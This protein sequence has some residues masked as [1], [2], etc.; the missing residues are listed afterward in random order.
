[1]PLTL[2]RSYLRSEPSSSATAAPSCWARATAGPT[3]S[4]GPA[5][6][7][8]ERG[9]QGV[10]S[11]KSHSGHDML[12]THIYFVKNRRHRRKE[13]ILFHRKVPHHR[14]GDAKVR[15][16]LSITASYFQFISAAPFFNSLTREVVVVGG[17]EEDGSVFSRDSV[18]VSGK[19]KIFCY[20]LRNRIIRDICAALLPR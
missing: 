19:E 15:F 3:S 18:Y 5:L 2:D 10:R 11:E 13:R 1:M 20:C 14:S 7:S 8:A 17:G 12:R 4:R 9:R 6:R 16:L